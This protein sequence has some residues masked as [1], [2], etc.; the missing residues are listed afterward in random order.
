MFDDNGQ[1]DI[2]NAKTKYLEKCEE[3]VDAS[4]EQIIDE[5]DEELDDPRAV[6]TRRR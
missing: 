4:P 1:P 6:G 5:L 3:K 2:E